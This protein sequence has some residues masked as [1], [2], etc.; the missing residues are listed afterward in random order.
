MSTQLLAESAAAWGL[1]LSHTQLDQFATY[2]KE[3][4]SWNERVNLTA[5]TDPEGITIRHFIDSLSCATVWGDNPSSLIDI[6]TGAGFP[7]LP[8]KI[9]RPEL[10]L[11]LVESI[12]K[13]TAFL[14]HIVALLG[15]DNV[16]VLDSRAEEIGRKPQHREQYDV[17]LGRAVADMRVL[18][19]YCLPLCKVG[20][21]FLAP[22]SQSI[23]E[24]LEGARFAIERLGG[25]IA[26]VEKVVLPQSAP[27]GQASTLE[28]VIVVVEKTSPTP[29]NYPRANGVPSRRPLQ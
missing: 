2:A 18:A 16:E 27:D 7:G 13:K 3:L 14:R 1:T 23:Q 19:E 10:K 25:Q 17:A 24:E 20:G 9:L 4:Q 12:G 8:L 28:R 22:K 15:L 21:R 6:G 26:G 29:A 5:I 11:A